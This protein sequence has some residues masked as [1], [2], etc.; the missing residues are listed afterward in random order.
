MGL[1]FRKKTYILDGA[2]GTQLQQA[3][4]RSD[5]DQNDYLLEHPLD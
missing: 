4:M 2:M 1:D 5:E 3:G